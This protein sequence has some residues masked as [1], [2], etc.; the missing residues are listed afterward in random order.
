MTSAQTQ[1]QGSH[2]R[3]AEVGR[4]GLA[5]KTNSQVEREVGLS[6][7]VN[8]WNIQ[9]VSGKFFPPRTD[10]HEILGSLPEHPLQKWLWNLASSCF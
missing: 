9:W 8:F 2:I 5:E 4:N 7:K 1:L 10:Q 3:R 6:L